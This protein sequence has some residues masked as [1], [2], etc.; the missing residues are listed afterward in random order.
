MEDYQGKLDAFILKRMAATKLPAVSLALIKDGEVVYRRGYGLRDW[1]AGLPATPSTLY[2]IGSVTKSFTCLALMQLQERG[3]LSVE[4]PVAKYLPFPVAPAG[5]QIRLKHFM[6]HTSGIPALGYAEQ[7]LRQVIKPRRELVFA[8]GP[9]DM[10][11]FM[12][13]AGDWAHARP[14]E[15][16]FYLNEGFA[17]LG[18]IVSKVSGLAYPDYVK[19]HILAPLGMARSFFGRAEVEGDG[20]AAVPSYTDREGGLQGADYSYGLITAE[21][22]LISSV[23]DMARYVQMYLRGGL[24]PTGSR[25]IGEDS[26]AEMY[27]PRV[28]TP[29][30]HFEPLGGALPGGVPVAGS[31]MPGWYG[32]GL[33][34]APLGWQTMIRHGGS[35]RVATAEMAFIPALQAGVVVLAS[36]GGYP[37]AQFGQYALA[38]AIG[39]NPDELPFVLAETRLEALTGQY[40]TY[41]GTTGVKV[42]RQGGF[43][44]VESLDLDAPV[45]TVL[46][47]EHLADDEATFWTISGTARMPVQFI[48]TADGGV[49]LVLE[50]YKYR[51]TGTRP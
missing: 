26:L 33:S 42:K 38:Q 6:S 51:R 22:G 47:P 5:E 35:V 8:G 16:W 27:R 2:G 46:V 20:D 23:D 3:L 49:E 17:L 30:E 44:V 21:G 4:D 43:L 15:R 32:F 24:T 39:M 31:R 7:V 25:L 12:A 1:H 29:G 14:G 45:T 40:E 50:R 10:L 48:A 18:A 28:A 19:Q 34:L 37:M 9:E 41:R 11:A 36:G 13:D